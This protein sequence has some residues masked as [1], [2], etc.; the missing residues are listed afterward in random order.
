[1]SQV[2]GFALAV[3]IGLTLGLVGGGGSILTVPVLVYVMGYEPKSA[4]AMSLPVVGVT[5]L[6]GAVGHWREGNLDWRAVTG[7]APLAMVGAVL[8]ARLAALV[9]ARFQLTLLAVVMAAAGLL[10]LRNAGSGRDDGGSEGVAGPGRRIAFA[11]TG[12]GVG[13]LTGLVGVGG[14]FL[15]V[16]A[17]VLLMGVPMRRAVGT[18]L[19]VIG[20]STLTGL[21]AYGG[22]AAV[23]WPAAAFFALLAT[24]GAIAGARLVRH[25]AARNLRRGF[26]VLVLALAAFL[27]YETQAPGV[28]RGEPAA[29]SD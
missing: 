27:L 19:V 6:V 2:I 12:L 13:V 15:I 17:L 23:A 16:P 8:G 26:A 3:L 25:V 9:S 20:L 4:V 21:V 14:G 28:S 22:R 18:S 10:L 29:R 1:M 11:A 5:S 7:F 24:A